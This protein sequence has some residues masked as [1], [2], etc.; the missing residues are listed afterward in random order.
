VNSINA[1]NVNI[2]NTLTVSGIS[3]FGNTIIV[4]GEA[5]VITLFTSGG[6]NVAGSLRVSGD[7]IVNGN[8]IYSGSTIGDLLPAAN[9]TLN[10]GSPSLVWATGYINIINTSSISITNGAIMNTASF[11]GNV[12]MAN[13][14]NVNNA[15]TIGNTIVCSVNNFTFNN[16]N[17][18]AT[19]D[20]FL[21]SEFRSVEYLIQTS[22]TTGQQVTKL[23]LIHNDTVAQLTEYATISTNSSMGIFNA[24]ISSGTLNLRYTPVSN[25]VT[26]KLT[27]TA[28]RV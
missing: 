4:S 20:S 8:F 1:F 11:S 27:R 7:L 28:I 26:V 18:M 21:T 13:S 23:I 16:S 25:N 22:D 15:V 2:S 12:N 10:L 24:A 17:T 5:N 6:A 19:I 3:N 14:L 9:N